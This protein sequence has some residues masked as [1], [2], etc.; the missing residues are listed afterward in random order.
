MTS[1]RH[2]LSPAHNPELQKLIDS[3]PHVTKD[4]LIEAAIAA[5]KDLALP[6]IAVRVQ[7]TGDPAAYFRQLVTLA[8]Y[9]REAR[10]VQPYPAAPQIQLTPDVPEALERISHEAFVK[11]VSHT[12][13][14]RP[15]ISYWEV[16][17]GPSEKKFAQLYAE[18]F[19]QRAYDRYAS[20]ILLMRK[21]MPL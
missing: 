13:P 5:S 10:F 16:A 14:T 17:R 3:H 21:P 1:L 12:E 19:A 18:R 20:T 9:D 2:F 4:L 8:S 7:F 11:Q 6:P 15:S